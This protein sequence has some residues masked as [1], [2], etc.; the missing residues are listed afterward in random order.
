MKESISTVFKKVGVLERR[1]IGVK[2]GLNRSDK[3]KNRFNGQCAE[4]IC[5]LIVYVEKDY[6]TVKEI[7]KH[8]K[9][10]RTTAYRYL[11]HFQSGKFIAANEYVV[12][13]KLNRTY[14]YKINEYVK[15]EDIKGDEQ[16]DVKL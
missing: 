4:F 14:Y 15:F 12:R 9:V 8:F 1:G 11:K 5:K 3:F 10:D 6:R 16:Y 7:A 13:H 2:I